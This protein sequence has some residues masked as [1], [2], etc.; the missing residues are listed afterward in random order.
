MALSVFQLDCAAIQAIIQQLEDD[1]DSDISIDESISNLP[2]Y[3][4][5]LLRYEQSLS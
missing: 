2:E 3:L 5:N 1:V 4:V